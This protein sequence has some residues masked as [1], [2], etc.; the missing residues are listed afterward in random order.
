MV[1][2]LILS[3]GLDSSLALALVIIFFALQF[4][5]G[6]INI[7]WWGNTVWKNTADFLGLHLITLNLERLSGRRLGHEGHI[8]LTA[9]LL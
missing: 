2:A 1:D 8:I 7:N 5:K 3:A 4:P 9:V 6:G